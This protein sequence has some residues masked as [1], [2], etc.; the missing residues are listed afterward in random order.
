MRN[1]QLQTKNVL[2]N[3]IF[4]ILI[5]TPKQ[6]QANIILSQFQL[7]LV[8]ML[9]C[10]NYGYQLAPILSRSCLATI[11]EQNMQRCKT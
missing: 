1:V 11:A 10:I 9:F 3:E 7:S 8:K 4:T 2:K 6:Q 5:L